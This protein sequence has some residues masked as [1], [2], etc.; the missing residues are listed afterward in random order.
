MWTIK[1][2]LTTISKYILCGVEAKKCLLIEG[3]LR[4]PVMANLVLQL[5]ASSVRNC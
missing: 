5:Q 2:T 3:S 1:V 4:F